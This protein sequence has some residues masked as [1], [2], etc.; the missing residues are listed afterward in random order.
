MDDIYRMADNADKAQFGNERIEEM[1]N[2]KVLEFNVEKSSYV[3]IGNK[4]E[5]KKLKEQLNKQPLLLCGEPM[6]EVKSV[7]YL[8]DWVSF[9][10]KDSIHET[11]LKRIG[12]AKHSIYELRT[13][14][15]DSRAYSI[16]GINV[17]LSIFD[18]AIVP[19]LLHNAETWFGITKKTFKVLTDF[20]NSFFHCILR[21]S[22]GCPI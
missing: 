21:V 22:S 18:A 17:A 12:V 9:D 7:K 1:I 11:V 6:K 14:V 16:G 20:F 13:I 10:L 2:M 19:M 5:R 3:I 15:E 4:K 8:G